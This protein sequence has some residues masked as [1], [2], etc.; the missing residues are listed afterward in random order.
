MTS[1]FALQ[2]NKKR[3]KYIMCTKKHHQYASVNN[4]LMIKFCLA[5]EPTS[6]VHIGKKWKKWISNQ[7]VHTASTIQSNSRKSSNC[8]DIRFQ[9][10]WRRSWIMFTEVR[11]PSGKEPYTQRKTKSLL[12][13]WI[14]YN[15]RPTVSQ[16]HCALRPIGEA[17]LWTNTPFLYPPD[18]EQTATWYKTIFA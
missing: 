6:E 18:V 14:L 2:H 9:R 4:I 1:A 10:I 17:I 7:P 15:E 13:L 8:K 5:V 12:M 16:H 11:T 3:G